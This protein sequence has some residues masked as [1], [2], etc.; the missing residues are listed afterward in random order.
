MFKCDRCPYTSN[1]K[2][3][4]NDHI[5]VVHEG[6]VIRCPVE[7][8]NSSFKNRSNK[9]QHVKSMHG[10]EKFKCQDCD[11]VGTSQRVVRVHYGTHHGV[12][13]FACELC[14]FRAGYQYKIDRHTREKHAK[15]LPENQQK[16]LKIIT[17]EKRVPLITRR[18]N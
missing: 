2:S 9:R 10:T 17:C 7:G 15:E 16:S 1:Q 18:H 3:G 12:K 5:D 6:V 13:Y 4:I 11:Y 8:C 14:D